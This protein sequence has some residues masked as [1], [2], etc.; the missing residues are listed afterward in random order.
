MGVNSGGLIFKDFWKM[1]EGFY[2]LTSQKS[3][4]IHNSSPKKLAKLG[5][6]ERYYILNLAFGKIGPKAMTAISFLLYITF[7]NHCIAWTGITWTQLFKEWDKETSKVQNDIANNANIICFDEVFLSPEGFSYLAEGLIEAVQKGYLFIIPT[8][9]QNVIYFPNRFLI[10]TI[11]DEYNDTI[12][13]NLKQA[14]TR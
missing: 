11:I 14:K 4:Y 6:V 2:R 12:K 1:R 13:R 3:I 9:N 10:Q 7:Q 5:V 8:P